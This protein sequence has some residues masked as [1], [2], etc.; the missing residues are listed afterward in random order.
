M[1]AHYDTKNLDAM[2]RLVARRADIQIL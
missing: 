2:L 1:L